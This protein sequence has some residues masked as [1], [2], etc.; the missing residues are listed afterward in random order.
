[1]LQEFLKYFEKTT[2]QFFLRELVALTP[3][4]I[5]QEQ[6][7]VK[8]ETKTTET[9]T[10][11]IVREDKFTEDC[12]FIEK[13][14]IQNTDVLSE[15]DFLSLRAKPLYKIAEGK[16]RIIFDLFLVEKIFKGLY[17]IFN[18]LNNNLPKE[19][20]I[21]EFKSFFGKEFSEK[22]LAYKVIDSI[23][24]DKCIKFSGQELDNMKIDGAPDY[25]IRKG[26]NILLFESKDFLIK[27][28]KKLSFDY[29]IYEEEF[30]RVLYYE[31]MSNGKEK[32]KAVLQL[33][34]NI[35][36]LLKSEFAADKDYKYKD[37]SIYPI[38]LI[39]DYQYDVF[40]FN[41]LI[42]D[43]FQYELEQLKKDGL[44]VYRVKPL[45]IISIDTLIFHQKGLID[46]VS[47]TDLINM[48]IKKNSS[49]QKNNFKVLEKIENFEM[50]K[51]LPF[52]K[53]IE[54]YFD[55]NKLNKMPPIINDALSI[56]FFRISC[57]KY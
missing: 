5:Q 18:E 12:A 20:K 56:W 46:G 26:E 10:D 15:T 23:F 47:L 3:S 52:S 11:I 43:W 41:Y 19:R 30:T 1:M 45:T 53:F 55:N 34:N 38:L 49:K 32:P 29:N 16:Y 33:I 51:Y 25:Y 27:A 2:W 8:T 31:K 9:Y 14:A 22:I 6:L 57:E 36:K 37:I 4:I 7:K 35:E 17:F 44:F 50:S 39:H 24:A 48:Y 42:N 40:S 21:A 13:F 28:E 54:D